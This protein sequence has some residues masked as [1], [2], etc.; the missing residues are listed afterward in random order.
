[1]LKI[2]LVPDFYRASTREKALASIID[3]FNSKVQHEFVEKK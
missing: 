1:M 2:S 3:A